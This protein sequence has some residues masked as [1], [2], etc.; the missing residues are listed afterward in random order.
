MAAV[1]THADL[2][3]HNLNMS[4]SYWVCKSFH[5]DVDQNVCFSSIDNE[6]LE[7]IVKQKF[8]ED[9]Q[10]IS[11]LVVNKCTRTLMRGCSSFNVAAN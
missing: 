5:F 10:F 7:S 3:L 1:I 8:E 6:N 4:C 2:H 11:C 9:H